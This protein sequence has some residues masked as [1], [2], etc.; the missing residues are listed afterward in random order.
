MRIM[1]PSCSGPVRRLALVLWLTLPALGLLAATTVDFNREIRPVL[2][3]NCFACH[4]PDTA[5]VK[6][7]LRLDHRETALQPARSGK[8]AIVPGDPE[9]SEL[10]IRI[11]TED[12]D[13][14]MPPPASHKTL[15]PTQRELLRR[16]IAEGAEY[17]G[18]WAYERPERPVVPPDGN[19]IDHLVRTRLESLGLT[20]AA[21][22]DR[23]SLARRLFWDLIGLPPKP[24]EVAAFE[25][26]P[27]PDA[28]EKLVDRLLASPHYG[29][30]L[31]LGW[32]DVARFADTIGYHSDNPRPIWPYRDYVIR[33]F[34]AN[35]PFDQ[36]TREQLAGDLLPLPTLE[37][38]VA[39][40]FNRLLLTTE[41]GGAQPKDY[42]ARYLTDR[43]RAVGT[44]WLGQ[45]LG[46]ASCH[47]HK[48]DPITTRDFYSLGAFFADIKEPII[49][50]RGEGMLVPDANQAQELARLAAVV[51]RLEQHFDGPHPKLAPAFA[52]W[53]QAQRSALDREARWQPLAPSHA[54]SASE[55]TLKIRE[56]RSVLVGGKRPDKDT[57]T[58]QFTNQ[59]A[60][61]LGLRLEALPDDSLPAKGPG[62][63]DNGNFVLTELIARLEPDG[64]SPSP[65]HFRAA[66]ATFEQTSHSEDH[67]YGRWSA[68]AVIDNDAKGDDVGWAILPEAG[69]PNRV[70]LELD[71]PLTVAPGDTLVV[72]LRHNR[73]RGHH[74]LGCF[75]L[76]VTTDPNARENLVTM[77]PAK[78][79]ADL[80]R[81]P[82][83]QRD[84]SQT[85]KLFAQFK[86]VCAELAPLREELAA[87]RKA[88]KDYEAT[89]P[90]TLVS[91]V[92][93]PPRT[94]RILPRGN[95]LIETG[96]VVEPALP[97]YLVPPTEAAVNRRLTRL[98]LAN[99]LVSRDNPLTARVVVNR[100]WKQ[101]FGVGLSKVLDDFGA[102]GEPP[103]NPA[104]LDWLA[105]EFM[106]SGWDVRHLIRLM[107]LS[108]TYRQASI[109]PRD[110]LA[111]DPDNREFARQ[112]RWRIEAELVRDTAL[113]LAGLLT[114]TVGG[115]SIKPYQPDGYWENL[116]FPPRTYQA[117]TGAD[118]YRRGLYVWWQRSFLHPSLLAFDAPTREECAADRGRSNIPQQA[119]VLLN[120]PTYVEAARAFATRILRESEGDAAARLSWAW[121]QTLARSPA[122]EELAIL[123]A[124]LEKHLGEFRENPDGAA[125]FLRIGASSPL[126]D[127]D[128]VEL[129]A[130]TNIARA[131]LNLH[132]TITRS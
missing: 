91:E 125:A 51:S 57:Y 11:M 104:L 122:P 121:Q 54:V 105:S 128:P 22:A 96:D 99:W 17:R 109:A 116:N 66:R 58:L 52:R 26:D 103:R 48:F 7:R 3:D 94:V 25:Q 68:A 83:D 111:R 28:Y 124:L 118:Q 40:G 127:L 98:D 20:S 37:Q 21:E 69:K 90:R 10:I 49:G 65:V 55:A 97:G 27:A 132:E 115:P 16:W 106:D 119:L 8:P 72:E 42:E 4:G 60:G 33:A 80:L 92:Q 12:E 95:F 78:E 35:K 112:G 2:A 44:V 117:S 70:Q 18:H 23:R 79:V 67:P 19:P 74:T 82:P 53:E 45:T 93:D 73:G 6:S 29:E 114:P 85:A 50:S 36:F 31:A 87:A 62:R 56:D 41:E 75:R 15:T 126:G 77:P 32:L 38:K 81:V 110:V 101:F 24:G 102:Q 108:Q 5:K 43:V 64:A 123:R 47:D 129:A 120:D 130:W 86:A 30:R 14:V 34:N 63:A 113:S 61:I 84:A 76:A 59:L 1:L 13:D 89:I 9:A 71:Q 39:S 131:L 88:H 107:V 100:L 46:C